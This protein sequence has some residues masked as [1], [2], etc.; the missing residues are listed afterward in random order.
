MEVTRESLASALAKTRIV[1]EE[2]EVSGS[3]HGGPDGWQPLWAKGAPKEP[4]ELAEAVMLLLEIGQGE[5]A[6]PCH[7]DPHI[8]HQSCPG[9]PKWIEI[10]RDELAGLLAKLRLGI[11][12]AQEWPFGPTAKL[13]RPEAVADVIASHARGL[14]AN[15]TAGDVVDAHICCEHAVVD[16]AELAA[17][18]ALLAAL[19][20]V[21]ALR[22]D[23]RERVMDWARRRATDSQPPF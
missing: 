17:M 11:E 10:T 18:A 14:R 9:V 23:A 15:E 3:V 12:Q 13:S 20:L 21:S 7:P 16:D 22:P 6:E 1:I 5:P 4:G 8:P 19:P 2:P